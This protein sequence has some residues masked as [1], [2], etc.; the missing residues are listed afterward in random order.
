MGIPKKVPIFVVK[1]NINKKKKDMKK[2]ILVMM[3]MLVA[4]GV[5]AQNLLK[6]KQMVLNRY[7][8][9]LYA[10]AHFIL[11]DEYGNKITTSQIYSRYK[12]GYVTE[13]K[14]YYYN[15][16]VIDH[17]GAGYQ[18]I[19]SIGLRK[20]R[21]LPYYVVNI[22]GEAMVLAGGY[23][24]VKEW[25]YVTPDGKII[26]EEPIIVEKT[27]KI[28]ERLE[29]KDRTEEELELLNAAKKAKENGTFVIGYGRVYDVVDQ[30]PSFVGGHTALMDY[31]NN[32]V[33]YPIVAYENGV[34]GRVIV[35]FVVEKDGSLGDIKVVKSVDPSLDKEAVRVVKSMP[36]WVAGK[37]NGRCVR[38]KYNVPISFILG[39]VKHNMNYTKINDEVERLKNERKAAVHFIS[40]KKDK[41]SKSK[42]NRRSND[43]VYLM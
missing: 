31:L 1:F 3:M 9:T 11:T 40:D 36:K 19:D 15:Q 21:H 35:S 12:K 41:V 8:S 23:K 14:V 17:V 25:F 39:D 20:I 13:E 37:M 30:M 18:V 26:N 7:K 43:D 2:I 32:N 33:N 27:Y 28:I 5:N 24:Q 4:S 38:V 10:P 42:L 22:V 34:Q 6:I 16:D 29:D